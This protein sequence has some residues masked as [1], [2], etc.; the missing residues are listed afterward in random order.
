M[1]YTVS[2]FIVI[3]PVAEAFNNGAV[4]IGL[5]HEFIKEGTDIL[6]NKN[7]IEVNNSLIHKSTDICSVNSLSD[8]TDFADKSDYIIIVKLINSS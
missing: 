8:K 7:L 4:F 3:F 5:S 1:G 6:R 2:V